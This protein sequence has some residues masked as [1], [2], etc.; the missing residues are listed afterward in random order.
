MS[1]PRR[2]CVKVCGLTSLEDALAAR[3]AGAD[4]LG[5]IVKGES[6][7]RID[8]DAAGRIA[9]RL[10]ETTRVAVLVGPTP[11]EALALA[12]KAR[13]QRVQLHRVDITAWPVDFPLPVTVVVGVDADGALD[14]PLPGPDR[15]LMLDRADREKAGGTGR[16]FPWSTA[17]RLARG[18]DVIVAG[19]LDADNVATAIADVRPFGVDASSRLERAPGVKDVERVRRFVAAVRMADELATHGA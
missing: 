9:G 13:A 16:T 2:T 8:A 14:A 11:E 3:D 6:P 19:G 1:V 18:R 12:E 4:W 7:R 15:L 17:A 10:G 5:F